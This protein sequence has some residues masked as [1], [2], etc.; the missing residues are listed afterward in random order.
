M[1]REIK[2]VFLNKKKKEKVFISQQE[3]VFLKLKRE[4]IKKILH[5]TT[6]KTLFKSKT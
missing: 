1:I 5:K 3:I 6:K 4:K 2:R